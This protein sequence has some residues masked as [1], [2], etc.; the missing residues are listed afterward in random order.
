VI[1][2]VLKMHLFL[3][4]HCVFI[5]RGVSAATPQSFFSADNGDVSDPE[6]NGKRESVWQCAED[7]AVGPQETV[8]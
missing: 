8:E 2:G 5:T 1:V 6:A 4:I 7:T 3:E